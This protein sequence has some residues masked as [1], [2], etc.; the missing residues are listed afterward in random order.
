MVKFALMPDVLYNRVFYRFFMREVDGKQGLRDFESVTQEML[1]ALVPQ[2]FREMTEAEGAN[3]VVDILQQGHRSLEFKIGS[4]DQRMGLNIILGVE[5]NLANSNSS[6]C[7]YD[8]E[9]GDHVRGQ[10]IVMEFYF[11]LEAMLKEMGFTYYFGGGS[12]R[13][14][15]YFTNKLGR[16]RTRALPADEI[17]AITGFTE[18]LALR[19]MTHKKL[20]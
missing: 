10:H 17:R 18:D 14:V 6:V 12:E 16:Q 15:T 2:R 4:S 19:Y 8:F 5:P 13:N 1:E 11:K 20:N 7:V 9:H 3:V